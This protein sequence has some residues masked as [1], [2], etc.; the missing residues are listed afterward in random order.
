M[1]YL[2]NNTKFIYKQNIMKN[3]KGFL[4]L[5]LIIPVFAT[6]A[7]AQKKNKKMSKDSVQAAAIQGLLSSKKYTF[8]AEYAYPQSGGSYF[9]SSYFYIDITPDK[10]GS[11]LPYYGNSYS[12]GG[13][14]D[15][16]IKFSSKDFDYASA[17]NDG[18]WYVSIK[19]KDTDNERELTLSVNTDGTANLVVL[20]NTRQRMSYVG[21]IQ[22]KEKKVQ[23]EE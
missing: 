19:P 10:I 17:K 12:G 22:E 21:V 23:E 20:S 11:M 9:L 3:L 13:I 8:V 1:H 16:G 7:S 6:T 15:N 14:T 2:N 4:L 18:K 5:L